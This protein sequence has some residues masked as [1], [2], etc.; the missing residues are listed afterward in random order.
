MDFVKENYPTFREVANDLSLL[1]Y[2]PN[3]PDEHG[4]IPIGKIIGEDFSVFSWTIAPFGDG[5]A[6]ELEEEA[7]GIDDDG[8]CIP[9][10]GKASKAYLLPSE[11]DVST[12]FKGVF[13][14]SSKVTEVFFSVED[15]Y[16]AFLDVVYSSDR[17]EKYDEIAEEARKVIKGYIDAAKVGFAEFK[18]A[19]ANASDWDSYKNRLHSSK[20][21]NAML[22]LRYPFLIPYP[23]SNG[24]EPWD[25]EDGEMFS[26]T[27][28]DD[29]PDGWA[30]RFG[31]EVFEDIR[32]Q[33]YDDDS[34]V[35]KY[36]NCESTVYQIKEKFGGLRIYMSCFGEGQTLLNAYESISYN[37]CIGCGRADKTRITRGY[38][39]P[40]CW[41]EVLSDYEKA[42]QIK[43][44]AEASF[45][46][47]E[48]KNRPWNEQ[49][50]SKK[51]LINQ[52]AMFDY[53]L[54]T[55]SPAMSSC[56]LAKMTDKWV[57]RT[58]S[59]EINKA[60]GLLD[61][62]CAPN[63]EPIWAREVILSVVDEIEQLESWLAEGCPVEDGSFKE[64]ADSVQARLP[65][66][67]S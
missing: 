63:G 42:A 28:F 5:Y 67:F 15:A 22:C 33:N 23:V 46:S 18:E 16:D 55:T 17:T 32:N 19:F 35:W 38:I 29:L 60:E 37:V 10:S 66:W 56:E 6:I 27:H 59:G 14:D 61:G 44:A 52:Y 9:I 41:D 7:K 49:D 47:E 24:S 30:K 50:W 31:L 12:P 36:R 43:D 40:V 64:L 20:L 26:H 1:E 39:L 58:S 8:N 3:T 53:A 45:L 4:R 11:S 21:S 65:E 62:S 51:A 57:W 48:E 54:A 13:E 25:G 34:R 2:N